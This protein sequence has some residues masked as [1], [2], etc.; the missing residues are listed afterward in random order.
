MRHL[1]LSSWFFYLG[2]MI[3]TVF[4][5]T[6]SKGTFGAMTNLLAISGD[7]PT[8]P[9]EGMSI[10]VYE[11]FPLSGWRLGIDGQGWGCSLAGRALTW[12][13]QSPVFSS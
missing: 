5:S 11:T 3:F 4:I 7:L 10:F 9:I 2:V 1:R 13:A 8:L 12:Q 6:S